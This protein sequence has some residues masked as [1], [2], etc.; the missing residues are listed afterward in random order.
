MRSLAWTFISY[1]AFFYATLSWIAQSP[2]TDITV[3][4]AK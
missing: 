1:E 4:S 3:T 2:S